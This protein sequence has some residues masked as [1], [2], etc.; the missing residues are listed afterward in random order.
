MGEVR[1]LGR[2]SACTSMHK[3]EPYSGRP[4]SVSNVWLHLMFLSLLLPL[5]FL[6]PNPI[7]VLSGPHIT[8]CR[9]NAGE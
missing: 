5:L 7:A 8:P 9:S 6:P 3:P 1:L 2:D 4:L